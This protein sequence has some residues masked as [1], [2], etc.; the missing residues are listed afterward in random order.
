MLVSEVGLVGQEALVVL[1]L[2]LG[3]EDLV[4]RRYPHQGPALVLP[5]LLL[6]LFLVLVPMLLL[7][8]VLVPVLAQVQACPDRSSSRARS[9]SNQPSTRWL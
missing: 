6:L 3:P 9:V 1:L 8:L 7:F 2:H 5:L 4:D